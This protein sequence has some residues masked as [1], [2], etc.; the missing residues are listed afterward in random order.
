M[1][2]KNFQNVFRQELKGH[3]V[4]IDKDDL[5]V[6]IQGK[7]KKK[8]VGLFFWFGLGTLAI[9]LGLG[10]WNS[11]G[12]FSSDV[13]DTKTVP[14]DIK[15]EESIIA[16]NA[17]E[18][19]GNPDDEIIQKDILT[20]AVL[21]NEEQAIYVSENPKI[22]NEVKVVRQTFSE[23]PVEKI[24]IA[25]NSLESQNID[26]GVNFNSLQKENSNIIKE[27]VVEVEKD[28]LKVEAEIGIGI[29]LNES[30]NPS[31]QSE[32][33]NE[34]IVLVDTPDVNE[35]KPEETKTE[36]KL[37]LEE[38]NEGDEAKS[39]IIPVDLDDNN[40]GGIVKDSPRKFFHFEVIPQF[41]Y[42]IPIKNLAAKNGLQNEIE[43][44][45]NQIETPLENWSVGLSL[46]ANH[47]TGLYLRMG[48]RFDQL[49]ENVKFTETLKDPILLNDVILKE[50]TF[51]DGSVSN[52]TGDATGA[53]IS[54][55][56]YN[57]FNT[58]KR[59]SVP[60]SL[61]YEKNWK[62]WAIDGGVDFIFNVSHTFNGYILENNATDDNYILVKD[63]D[64]FKSRL[65]V[66]SRLNM[67]VTYKLS[68]FRIRLSPFVQLNESQVLKADSELNQ[69]YRYY[70][71]SLS[72]R[73]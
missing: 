34:N 8:R 48:I 71:V 2:K 47:K 61:G 54:T 69:S 6:G 21:S 46:Q 39:S 56:V 10:L 20:V 65:D 49:Q 38:L 5:W 17:V 44:F 26:Q 53:R 22:N 73:L 41:E 29:I 52:V 60:L 42:G 1:E 58:Y 3:E 14:L 70:G 9:V 25:S 12:D 66:D 72:F 28:H 55:N 4:Y 50:V 36:S 30:K 63:A 57:V 24:V 7:K 37:F 64:V 13:H 27:N 43:I 67:G 51:F 68:K 59:L 15:V 16:E 23:N 19:I 45:R 62:N 35:A 40:E 33:E 18:I 32:D 31:A 11:F